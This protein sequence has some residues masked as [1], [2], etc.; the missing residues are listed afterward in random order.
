MI[1]SQTHVQPLFILNLRPDAVPSP[2]DVRERNNLCED[3]DLLT[4]AMRIRRGSRP[5]K[6]VVVLRMF[7]HLI[8]LE[9]NLSFEFS[10]SVNECRE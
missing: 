9:F 10:R 2:S 4:R 8:V 7:S 1:V 6:T 3:K 5:Q